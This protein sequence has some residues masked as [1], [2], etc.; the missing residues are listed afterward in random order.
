MKVREL[1]AAL[2]GFDQDFDVEYLDTEWGT[3]GIGRVE[4]Y[5]WD[6]IPRRVVIE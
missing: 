4:V 3:T 6:T 1:I 2:Q 5:E